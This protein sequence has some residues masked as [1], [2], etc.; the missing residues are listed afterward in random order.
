MANMFNTETHNKRL[1]LRLLSKKA[2]LKLLGYNNLK[3]YA[4]DRQETGKVSRKQLA[5]IV[6]MNGADNE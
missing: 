6:L 5:S 1:N 3:S 4:K 2:L